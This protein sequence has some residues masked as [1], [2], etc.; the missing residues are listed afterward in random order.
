MSHEERLHF[1]TLTQKMCLKYPQIE[2]H[3]IIVKK[4]NVLSHITKDSNKLY[5]YMIKLSLIDKMAECDVVHL[6]P[7]P[8][9]IKVQSGNSLHDYLQ[10][11]LWFSNKATTN[12]ITTPLDSKSCIGLQFANMLAGIVQSRYERNENSYY[13]QIA[14]HLKIKKL[15][16]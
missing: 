4:E 5:N 10:T 3:A 16:F 12:L 13:S 7:D 6:I 2:L 1:A 15:Y 8:R 14:P 11:E 9:T